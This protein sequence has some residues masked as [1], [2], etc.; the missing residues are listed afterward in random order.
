MKRN[1]TFELRCYQTS[2]LYFARYLSSRDAAYDK[3]F[4]GLDNSVLNYM[5]TNTTLHKL[6]KRD[7]IFVEM[8]GFLVKGSLYYKKMRGEEVVSRIR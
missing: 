4:R 1:P 7:V 8:G 6:G 2:F 5:G 3:L